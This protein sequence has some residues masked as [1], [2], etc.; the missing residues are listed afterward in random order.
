MGGET[1]IFFNPP[2]PPY[3]VSGNPLDQQFSYLAYRMGGRQYVG[4]GNIKKTSRT[5]V[6]PWDDAYHLGYS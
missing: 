3:Q 1:E 4:E 2:P 5:V 6:S